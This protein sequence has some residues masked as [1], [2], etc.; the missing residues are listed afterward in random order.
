MKRIALRWIAAASALV[1]LSTQAARRPRY[2]GELRIETRA[3]ENPFADSV[4]ETLIKL[5]RRGEPQPWLA[6]SWSHDAARKMWVFTPR[7]NVVM[8]N[9]AVWSPG[10]VEYPDDRPIEE[11]SRAKNVIAV[12]AA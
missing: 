1:A 3:S 6:I 10:A 4:F 7:A 5:D 8:H 11:F 12:R 9:G 2:G